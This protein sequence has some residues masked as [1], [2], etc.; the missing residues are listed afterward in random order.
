MRT[1]HARCGTLRWAAAAVPLLATA[2]ATLGGANYI[3]LDEEWELGRELEADLA[4]RLDLVSDATLT[5]WVDGVGQRMVGRT[6]LGGRPWRFHVVRDASINAFNV[7]GGLVYVHTGLIARSGSAA[8]LAGAL[9]H[10]IGHGVA[11]HGTQRLSQRYEASLLAGI[12]LGQ[13]PGLVAELGTQIA[14]AGAFASF[15]RGDER[16]ADELG[17]ELM[18]ATGYHPEGL[19]RLLERLMEE[20]SGAG[21]F[22]STHPAPAERRDEVRALTRGMDTSRLRM[23]EDGFAAVRSRASGYR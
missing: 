11:R 13:N 1:E 9:A 14:A 10:E 19:A 8:E 16:E 22:F 17:V 23:D 7:P 2:C 3:S 20:G 15:S 12:L 18:A 4:G 21:G 6:S 5:S